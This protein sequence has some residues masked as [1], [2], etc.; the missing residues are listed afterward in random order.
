MSGKTIIKVDHATVRFNL[1]KE[2]TVNLKD[3]VIQLFKGQLLFQEFFALKDVSLTVKEGESWG[4]VGRNGSGKST[5]LKLIAGVLK[6]YQGTVRVNGTTSPL[7]ELGAGFDNQ[8]TARENIYLNGLMLGQTMNFMKTHF[9][10]I[11]AFSELENFI[12]VP[13]KN[14]SSGMRSRLGFSIAA[15]IKSQILIVDEVLSTGD[16]LFREKCEQRMQTLLSDGT[17]LLFVSHSS[18]AVKKLCNNAI[19]LREGEVVMSG[20]A[21]EVLNSYDSATK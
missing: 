11:V 21:K 13:L 6:P 17:T 18:D 2:R 16:R 4:I 19:W 5:L 12:D 15:T 20:D 8:L 7:L 3:Y 10:E 14:F 9:D 1:S